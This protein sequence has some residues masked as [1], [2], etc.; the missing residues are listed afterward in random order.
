[1]YQHSIIIHDLD[2]SE[3]EQFFDDGS[4]KYKIELKNGLKHGTYKEYY[5]GGNIRVKGK[6]KRDLREGS[7]RL[8]DEDGNLIEEILFSEGKEEEK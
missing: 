1:M 4:V 7:W 5:P 6:Y 8:Y 2:V 3:M